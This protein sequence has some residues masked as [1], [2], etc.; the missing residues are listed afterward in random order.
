MI[1]PSLE[2]PILIIMCGLPG[3]G[4]STVATLI[5]KEVPKCVMIVSDDI[6]RSMLLSG[7]YRFS[8]SI[9]NIVDTVVLK[10]VL[11]CL[12]SKVNVV[13]VDQPN[14]TINDR[15]TWI[16]LAKQF[17]YTPLIAFCDSPL[18]RCITNRTSKDNNRGLDK[19]HW[20]EYIQKVNDDF[21]KP[22]ENE[23]EVYRIHQP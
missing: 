15:R 19:K 22:S 4:K 23:C 17:E 8:Q 9:N 13:I 6:L 16:E 11:T 1:L 3:S 14:T 21:E 18:S 7:D 10:T 20:I 2:L 12:R 5:A